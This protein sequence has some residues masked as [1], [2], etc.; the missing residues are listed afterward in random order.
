MIKAM[1]NIISA[2]RAVLGL[3]LLAVLEEAVALP[4]SHNIEDCHELPLS[5]HSR[6]TTG[7]SKKTSRDA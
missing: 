5:V 2:A 3:V 6:G 1:W 7:S 4:G